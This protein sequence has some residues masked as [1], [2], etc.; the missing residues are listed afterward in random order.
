MNSQDEPELRRYEDNLA[1]TGFPLEYRVSRILETNGWSVISNRYYID[2]LQPQVREIDIVAYRSR[3]LDPLSYYTVLVVSCKKSEDNAWILVARDLRPD[4]PNVSWRPQHKWTNDNILE[5]MMTNT[6]WEEGFLASANRESLI[7]KIFDPEVHVF[8]FQEMRKSTGTPQNDKAIFSA[9]TS[10]MKAQAYELGSLPARRT[11]PSF[12]DFNLLSVFDGDLV[13]IHLSDLGAKA[14]PRQEE[15][16]VGR[17]I[18]NQKQT[19]AR[20][21]FVRFDSLPNVVASYA[22][23]H[24]YNCEFFPA[25][26]DAFYAEAV[27]DPQRLAVLKPELFSRLHWHLWLAL[28]SGRRRD[29]NEDRLGLEWSSGTDTLKITLDLDDKEIK[30]LSHDSR[31]L[32]VTK[33]ALKAVYR[34]EGAFEYS[35]E[36]PF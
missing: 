5:F 34:Y 29:L 10:L 28:P 16:Y 22:Q 8:A 19:Q 4:D 21:H 1:R 3:K 12:Y 17:Y 26:R 35:S 27:R 31:L 30:A 15:K 33:A 14:I 7:R 24:E 20:V 18:V 2:D 9:V 25:L 6:P 13:R 11:T 23:L 36:V 32:T